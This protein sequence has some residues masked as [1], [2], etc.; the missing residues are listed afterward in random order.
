MQSLVKPGDEVSSYRL[1]ERLHTDVF[2]EIWSARD[3]A[4]RA[5][6]VRALS[7]DVGVAPGASTALLSIVRRGFRHPHVATLVDVVCDRDRW[8]LVSEAVE[9]QTLAQLV[10]ARGPLSPDRAFRLAIAIGEGLAAIHAVGACH[11]RL[12]P[13]RIVVRGD[14]ATI[15]DFGL[16]MLL[17]DDSEEW[18][19]TFPDTADPTVAFLS[20]EQAAGDGPPTAESDVWG[21]GAVLYF[22]THAEAP[23]A[24]RTRAELA[25]AT[26]RRIISVSRAGDRALSAMIAPCLSREPALR[27]LLCEVL[28]AARDASDAP[29]SDDVSTPGASLSFVDAP[30]PPP[31]RHTPT[32]IMMTS[33]FAGTLV[34]GLLFRSPPER[35]EHAS[36]TGGL[37]ALAAPAA[38]KPSPSPSSSVVTPAPSHSGDGHS[39]PTKKSP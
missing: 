35:I 22:A 5:L 25:V 3:P 37:P 30:R 21:L 20:P 14:E 10:T 15:V 23:F 12:D 4:G 36:G 2:G 31:R 8:F 13:T 17:G 6:S 19:T 9:G 28:A 29:R 18:R 11:G 34:L 38:P 1:I 26:A 27:P 24:A 33:I 16:G 32:V 7:S 39:A